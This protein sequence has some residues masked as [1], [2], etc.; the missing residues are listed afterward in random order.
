MAKK[1]RNP[2][3]C[4]RSDPLKCVR[5]RRKI[6]I[7]SGAKIHAYTPTLKSGMK[8]VGIPMEHGVFNP[9]NIYI[10]HAKDHKYRVH[11]NQWELLI[12]AGQTINNGYFEHKSSSCFETF[13]SGSSLGAQFYLFCLKCV[14][15]KIA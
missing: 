2:V 11:V 3:F 4:M 6:Q 5:F 12:D 15:L 7:Q 14:C 1:V 8:Y 10:S 9:N 13:H